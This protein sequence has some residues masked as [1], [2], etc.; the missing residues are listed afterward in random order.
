MA[1]EVRTVRDYVQ[2]TWLLMNRA[3]CTNE[4]Y[5]RGRGASCEISI[6]FLRITKAFSRRDKNGKSGSMRLV[7]MRFWNAINSAAASIVGAGLCGIKAKSHCR[8]EE[9]CL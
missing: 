4:S 7:G 8:L 6:P 5:F 2:M 3:T 9:Q 1:V